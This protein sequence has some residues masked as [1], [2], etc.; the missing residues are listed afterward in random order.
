MRA[1]IL[2]LSFGV[3]AGCYNYNP[4]TTPTP[5]PGS[6]VA[7]TL[8]DSGSQE[9]ARYLGPNVFVVRGRYLGDSDQG[10]LLS[11][12]S[13]ELKRGNELSWEG[14]TVALPNGAIASLD[15]RRLAK[16]RSILLASVG[17]GG[18]VA[19]TLAFTLNGGGTPLGPGRPRPN[20]Q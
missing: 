20:P 3:S 4:L 17:A 1:A 19:T 8:T 9:L 14:E 12:A 7:V 16:G 5:Q 18:L 6:Y 2:I 15:V 13:V 10:L 11:V